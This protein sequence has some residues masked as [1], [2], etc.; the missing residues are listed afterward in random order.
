MIAFAQ[1]A[2][3]NIDPKESALTKLRGCQAIA[4][5]IAC[6]GLTDCASRT[7]TDLGLLA[8]DLLND[9]HAY[10]IG[11]ADQESPV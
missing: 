2:H 8:Y 1:A 11:T 9:V 10:L 4:D 7:A 5:V 3:D 6:G